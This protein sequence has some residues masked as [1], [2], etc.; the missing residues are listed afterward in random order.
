MAAIPHRGSLPFIHRR[1]SLAHRKSD[2]HDSLLT[3][4]N[5]TQ[6]IL[7]RLTPSSRKAS[8]TQATLTPTEAAWFLSLPEKV[9][10]QNFTKEEQ[11]LIRAKSELVL[12]D[13]APDVLNHVD[14]PQQ[15]PAHLRAKS[16]AYDALSRPEL[17]HF[18]SEPF[19]PLFEGHK[20]PS[21]SPSIDTSNMETPKMHYTAFNENPFA[22]TKQSSFLRSPTIKQDGNGS[23]QNSPTMGARPDFGRSKTTPARAGPPAPIQIQKTMYLND[24]QTKQFLRLNSNKFEETLN[25]GFPAATSTLGLKATPW[26][27]VSPGT[28]VRLNWLDSPVDGEGED[29]DFMDLSSADEGDLATPTS[30]VHPVILRR[31]SSYNKPH[32]MRRESERSAASSTSEHREAESP[33]VARNASSSSYFEEL[34]NRD[35][36]LRISLTKPELRAS[37]EELYGWQDGFEDGVNDVA[38]DDKDPLAL[39]SLVFSDDVS[40]LHGAFAQDMARKRGI[41]GLFRK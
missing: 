20:S 17:P 22:Q 14:D 15:R 11:I 40:G 38:D 1:S 18:S 26:D 9:R 32:R 6:N 36:T 23:G 3:V 16:V 37:D 19:M 12:L 5:H 35:M 30:L 24:P 21:S 39:E 27:P 10:R 2:A 28:E 31:E 7:A 34:M 41:K 33:F 25:F 13:S 8:T 4:Q 29:D